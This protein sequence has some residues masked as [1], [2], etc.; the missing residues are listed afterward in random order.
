MKILF[1]AASPYSAWWEGGASVAEGKVGKTP[2]PSF[3]VTYHAHQ[4]FILVAHSDHR[5]CF[6]PPPPISHPPTSRRFLPLRIETA[7]EDI[8]R[9]TAG[10]TFPVNPF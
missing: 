1:C 2:M 7:S 4:I 10:P 6:L 9:R 5:S 8:F 3:L